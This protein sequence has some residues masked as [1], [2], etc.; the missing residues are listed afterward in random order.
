M[1]RPKG[2]K[3]PYTWRFEHDTHDAIENAKYNAFWE[4]VE[5]VAKALHNNCDWVYLKEK[6]ERKD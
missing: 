1:W 2:L 6:D 3:N 4:G 5:A